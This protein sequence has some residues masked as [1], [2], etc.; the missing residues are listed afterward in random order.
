MDLALYWFYGL[1]ALSFFLLYLG[2][3]W[4]PCYQQPKIYQPSDWLLNIIGLFIQGV[5][6]PLLGI[7]FAYTLFPQLDFLKPGALKLSWF[8]A[9][10]FNIIV[11]DFLYYWQHRLF[12]RFSF[13]WKLHECHHSSPRVDIWATSRNNLWVNFLFVYLLIN[14]VIG[15]LCQNPE[16][17]FA[18]SML[19][20]SLDI[21]RHSKIDFKRLPKQKWIQAMAKIIVMPWMHHSHHNMLKKAHNFGAN[22]IIW[23]KIFKTFEESGQ[24]NIQYQLLNSS[25][26]RYQFYYPFTR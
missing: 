16:G 19:T 20:A 3:L 15:Y 9:F 21:F 17:F 22:L 8:G 5:L 6:I 7:V 13:L 10:L 14:P 1:P 11:I 12:H 18:G 24:Q 23:D 25:S 26:Y 2:E 4:L